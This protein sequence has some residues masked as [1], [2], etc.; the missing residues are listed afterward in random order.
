[1][2]NDPRLFIKGFSVHCNKARAEG[3]H[4]VSYEICCNLI[5]VSIL[6]PQKH[7][8]RR[9][10]RCRPLISIHTHCGYI[11]IFDLSVA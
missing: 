4:F 8:P 9:T 10:G 5:F 3:E 7:L 2:D 6:Q 11:G 1:M